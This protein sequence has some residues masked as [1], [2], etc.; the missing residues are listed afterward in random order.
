LAFVVGLTK[1]KT[2]DDSNK[3][4]RRRY[5]V[6]DSRSTVPA[7]RLLW[8]LCEACDTVGGAFRL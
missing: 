7:G 1:R 5:P 4:N 6:P 3:L 2:G 8:V